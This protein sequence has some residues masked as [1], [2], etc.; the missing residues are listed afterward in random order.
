LGNIN[1]KFDPLL[2][3]GSLV[4]DRMNK[5][6]KIYQNKLKIVEERVF[7]DEKDIEAGYR[8]NEQ[9]NE[10]VNR[11]NDSLLQ[12]VEEL[13]QKKLRN[14]D[15]LDSVKRELQAV[16]DDKEILSQNCQNLL[17]IHNQMIQLDIHK[18]EKHLQN[19]VRSDVKSA[20]YNVNST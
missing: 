4:V 14:L 1:S 8:V 16:L 10:D 12:R 6:E 18:N 13:R 7:R 11:Q 5:I 19:S 20:P 15:E 17:N 9:L 3:S 2:S